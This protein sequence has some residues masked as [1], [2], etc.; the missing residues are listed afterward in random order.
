MEFRTKVE[1]P[2]GQSKICHSDLLM[3]WGSCF[4]E[5]I[6]KLLVDNKFNCDINPFGILYNPFSIAKSIS[7]L[8]DEKVY[9]EDDLRFDKG[10]WYSL[11][12]HSSFSSSDKLECLNK[13][14]FR[15]IKGSATLGK[16]NWLIITWGTARVYEWKETGE[17]VGNCHKLPDKLFVRR[18]LDVDEIVSVYISLLEKIR[19]VNPEVQI[20]FTVS[21]IRHAKDGLH[22]NQLSKAVLLLA[23]EKIC[24]KFSYCHYFRHMRFCWTNCV[25]I[26]FMPMI[27]FIRASLP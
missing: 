10:I 7:L 18:L 8:L 1:L 20:L 9:G 13:I 17:V 22:G 6:G 2:V 12:H 19:L 24:Q 15:M 25:I 16:A 21:P 3:S 23:I 5:N 14:N 26:V 11:M 27:C 4:S